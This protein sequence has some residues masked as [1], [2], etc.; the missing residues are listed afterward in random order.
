MTEIS[1]IKLLGNIA[2]PYTS[3]VQFVLNLKSIKYEFIEE[4]FNDKSEL[5]LTSNPL[6]KR[7]PVLIQSNKPPILE[8]LII[9]DYLEQIYPDVYKLHPNDHADQSVLKFWAYYIDTEFFPL[10]G[11]LRKTPD[12][13]GKEVL[14]KQIIEK[15]HV[16]ENLFVK[17]SNG[18]PYF[19]GDDVGYL[20]VVLGCFL[21]WTKFVG[22]H[23]NFKIFD[24]VRTPNLIEWSKRMLSHESLKG[25]IPDQEIHIDFYKWLTKARPPPKAT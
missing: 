7:V 17:F 24:E 6:F 22:N 1:Q 21:G 13:E 10:Y 8:S 18:K 3:R 15:S 4:D 14:K 2:S 20:D 12:K 16:L 23:N 11:R 5:L 25:V 9:I 19:G